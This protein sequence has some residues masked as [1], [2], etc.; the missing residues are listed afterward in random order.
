MRIRKW[1]S[2]ETQLIFRLIG[3]EPTP[4]TFVGPLTDDESSGI[5][6]ENDYTHA[7]SG[8][9]AENVNGVEFELL[10][11]NVTPDNFSWEVSSIKNSWITIMADGM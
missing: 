5:S 6:S 4:F 2:G 8:G 11:A 10:N 9:G 7:I 3:E 1:E